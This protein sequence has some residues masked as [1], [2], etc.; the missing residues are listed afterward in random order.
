MLYSVIINYGTGLSWILVKLGVVFSRVNFRN[1]KVKGT[2]FCDH[3]PQF[4]HHKSLTPNSRKPL[5]IKVITSSTRR[6]QNYFILDYR[7]F[8]F[9]V[10]SSVHYFHKT[11]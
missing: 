7:T 10:L 2:T 4:V 11:L 1:I 5:S 9:I 6:R 3:S 8:S